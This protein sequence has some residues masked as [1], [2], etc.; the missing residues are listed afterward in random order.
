LNIK[1][2]IP[3]L[4]KSDTLSLCAWIWIEAL[5]KNQEAI[6]D[7]GKPISIMD[8][9]RMF[10]EFWGLEEDDVGIYN[11]RQC[12]YRMQAKNKKRMRNE[13]AVTFDYHGPDIQEV[14]ESIE[15]QLIELNGHKYR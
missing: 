6:L 5:I 2:S 14:L 8:A 3:N 4:Y 15:K 10:Q 9:A 13:T 11:I 1:E 7:N 12:Y